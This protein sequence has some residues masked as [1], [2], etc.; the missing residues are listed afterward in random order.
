MVSKIYYDQKDPGLLITSN[1]EKF[2]KNMELGI[3]P[4]TNY[5]E[6]PIE[7]IHQYKIKDI[8]FDEIDNAYFQ[9]I[10]EIFS[11][12]KFEAIAF[13]E[14]IADLS[15]VVLDVEHLI[16]GDKSKINLSS[17]NFKNLKEITFFVGKNF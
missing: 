5:E 4:K 13:H 6:I 15:E 12:Y 17:N 9:S 10:K 3:F 14:T 7:K 1:I 8:A 2:H 11:K 16:V